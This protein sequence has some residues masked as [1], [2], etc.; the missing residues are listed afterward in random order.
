MPKTL[1]LAD[2]SV[3]IQ[4]VVGI[5]FASEDVTLIAV[6]NGDDALERAREERPDAILADV[7]MP[8]RNGY[9]VCEAVKS[10]PAL[11][12]IPVLLLTG[13]FETFDAERASAVGA[14]GHIAKP[15]EAQALVDRVKEL[16]TA[17][18]GPAPTPAPTPEPAPVADVQSVPTAIEGAS[19]IDS[20]NADA[21]DFFDEELDIA[22]G[23]ATPAAA[24][25]SDAAGDS[26]FEF[27]DDDLAF[28]AA[29]PPASAVS[30]PV[31]EPAAPTPA[32]TAP[33]DQVDADPVLDAP[34]PL[35]D[36]LSMPAE[37]DF[38][39]SLAI[40]AD[41]G[42][43]IEPAGDVQL[44]ASTD[45]DDDFSQ[46]SL[47]PLDTAS[48]V[49]EPFDFAFEGSPDSTDPAHPASDVAADMLDEDDLAQATI[50][51]PHG[52][53]GYDVSSSDLGPPIDMDDGPEA[54]VIAGMDDLTP[55]PPVA[56]DL[57]DDLIE[58]PASSDPQPNMAETVIATD[59]A[60]APAEPVELDPISME[61]LMDEPE[62]LRESD[63]EPEMAEAEPFDA[64]PIAMGEPL[65]GESVSLES[66]EA[67][68]LDPE[69]VE[70]VLAPPPLEPEPVFAATPEPIGEPG[71]VAESISEPMPEPVAAALEEPFAPAIE[72]IAEEPLARAE[73]VLE[74]IE[75]QLREQIHDTLEKIA[76][77]SFSDV[78]DA[79]VRQS[80]ERVE[81][82]A[83]E[84][85]PQ[86]AETLIRE[87]IRK[88]KGEPPQDD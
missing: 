81:A 22:P 49:H 76:W 24:P 39:D 13:T 73:A 48:S 19:V 16:F 36:A 17:N 6:D 23:A 40:D 1:L 14:A 88:L 62:M 7:V 50:L 2:D 41:L 38:S 70:T 74:Q 37:N 8:G 83:W 64:E 25:A 5:S 58:A 61:P 9:E 10:D 59:F 85:I 26:A 80:V 69:P 18:S 20:G 35:N 46:D 45:A 51:D 33:D 57:L 31:A 52:A 67:V 3:T 15:F 28:E 30:E 55:A 78:T 68:T 87:E 65:M 63:Q 53:S 44:G 12:H 66:I 79:I 77:E 34:D 27:G 4:K 43:V 29:A 54:T 86:L 84:V 11:A 82:I 75:P 32:D 42:T 60:D 21:F 47:A 71:R 56:A 72:P